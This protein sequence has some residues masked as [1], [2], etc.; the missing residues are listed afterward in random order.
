MKLDRGLIRELRARGEDQALVRGT[1]EMAHTLGLTI[2]ADGVTDV[3][4]L[5]LLQGYG[6]D[7]VQGSALSGPVPASE[8]IAAGALAHRAV[9][10]A[11]ADPQIDRDLPLGPSG[12][13]GGEPDR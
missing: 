9:W 2:V 13:V 8:I 5:R 6:C 11:S 7:R 1:I 4:A 3:A 10:A 12:P